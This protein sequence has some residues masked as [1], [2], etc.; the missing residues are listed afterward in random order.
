MKK[1]IALIVLIV[2][3]GQSL[4]CV[5]FRLGGGQ[6]VRSAV[7]HEE[8]ESIRLDRS[9]ARLAP[10]SVRPEPMA[11]S[12]S[13][14]G[15]TLA[16]TGLSTAIGGLLVLALSF[17]FDPLPEGSPN[18][19]YRTAFFLTGAGLAGVGAILAVVGFTMDL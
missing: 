9:L 2:V 15:N 10:D 8:R 4:F 7:Y 6:P 19:D 16:W 3:A 1:G 18:F 12:S 5:D 11:S 14:G 13:G 17:A